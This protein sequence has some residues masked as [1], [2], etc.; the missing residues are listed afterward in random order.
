[1]LADFL[2]I[3]VGMPSALTALD[4]SRKLNSVFLITVLGYTHIK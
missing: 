4:M 1:M 3:G 2:W